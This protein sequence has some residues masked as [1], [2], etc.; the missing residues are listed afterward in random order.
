MPLTKLD[1]VR[2]LIEKGPGR[3]QRQIAEAI[4]GDDGYQQSV[5][6]ECGHL[7]RTEEFI[8]VGQGGPGD[9]LRYFPPSRFYDQQA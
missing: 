8:V 3:T 7:V 5:N 6:W 1:V 4:Y 2:F 9:P